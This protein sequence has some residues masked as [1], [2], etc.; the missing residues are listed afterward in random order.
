MKYYV[1]DSLSNFEFWSGAKD[2]AELLSVEQLDMIEEMMEECAPEDGWSDT[3]INDM[4]SFDFDTICEWLGY[5]DRE[6]LE[7]D[8]SEQEVEEAQEWANEISTDYNALFAIAHLNVEDYYF[9][10]E[11]GEKECDWN[12]ATEDFM[13]WWNN[14][15]EVDQVEEYRKYQD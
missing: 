1:E 15:D 9:I 6:H 12:L 8:I 14:L 7:K 10:N 4:F 13:D 5:K 11:D 2:N 3:A